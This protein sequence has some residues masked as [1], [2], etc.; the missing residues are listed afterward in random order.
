M[1]DSRLE[2]VLSTVAAVDSAQFTDRIHKRDRL[3]E[4]PLT[5]PRSVFVCLGDIISGYKAT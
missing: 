1:D 5:D 2:L 3:K 4:T